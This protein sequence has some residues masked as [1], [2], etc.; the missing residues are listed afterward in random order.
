MNK[1]IFVNLAMEQIVESHHYDTFLYKMNYNH[2]QVSVLELI[3]FCQKSV[4]FMNKMKELQTNWIYPSEMHGVAHNERVAILAYYIANALGLSLREQELIVDASFYHDVGRM[5]D[6]D[7]ILH[8]DRSAEMIDKIVIDEDLEYMKQLKC[9]IICHS[10]EDE[11]MD[12]LIQ[13]SNVDFEHTKI[14]ASILKD[15]DALDRIRFDGLDLSYLRLDISK[16]LLNASAA[17]YVSYEKAIQFQQSVICKK[18]Q[19]VHF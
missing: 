6:I 11:E 8:G 15:A 13:N 12:M 14:L 4:F 5:N 18:L 17:L 1:S 7:D 3:S 10:H 16:Q 9:V 19:T 2:C